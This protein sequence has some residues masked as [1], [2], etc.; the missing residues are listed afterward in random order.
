MKPKTVVRFARRS[1]RYSR[2]ETPIAY[3]IIRKILKWLFPVQPPEQSLK[4]VTE[5]N[6]G[7]IY[8]D[9]MYSAER[10][11]LFFG[12]IEPG[13]TDLIKRIV[14]PGDGCLDIGANIGALTLVMAF[15]TG[16][17][18]K[19]LAVESHPAMF[20]R[21]QINIELNRLDQV[22]IIPAAISE[23]TG[24]GILYA[25]AGTHYHQGGSS[26]KPS[27]SLDQRHEIHKMRG[28]ELAG[29][30]GEIRCKLIKIDVEGHDFIVLNE[31]TGLIDSHRPFII[32]EYEKSRWE[33]HG[34]RVEQ[35]IELLSPF[36]YRYYFM[37]K[38]LLYRMEDRLPD[39]CDIVCV[40]KNLNLRTPPD[41]HIY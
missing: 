11:I 21:F 17:S 37:D 27:K 12:V 34:C 26:L 33:E 39:A 20:E 38:N 2:F 41:N 3:R 30:F 22:E 4:M 15:Q 19:V 16:S 36:D 35:A 24:K 28:H 8:S 18:G 5:Y 32:T 40:P 25:K 29:R 7:L 13:I 10:E 6:Q 14:R 9:T 1:R 31:L 23:S